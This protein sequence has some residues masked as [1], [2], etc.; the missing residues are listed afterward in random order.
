MVFP[1]VKLFENP[2]VYS[3]QEDTWFLKDILESQLRHELL[4]RSSS[5]SVCEV[6]VGSG[7]ISIA[8]AKKFPMIHFI[9]VDISQT[10][11]NLCYKNILACLLQPVKF[12]VVCMNLLRGFNPS[13]FHPNIIF[14]NPPYVRTS[15][16]EMKKGFLEKA[17]AGGPSG[18]AIIQEFLEDLSQ[19]SFEKV[20]FLSSIFNAND[21]LEK[22]Y[23]NIFEFHVVAERKIEN[24]RLLCYEV[25]LK[26]NLR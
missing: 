11:A 24:E 17:W 5:L 12:D 21:L 10:A 25:A 3:P 15:E 2:E 18:I 19:F 1:D 22:N 23:H 4:S 26:E 13:N 7:F 6:G 8:L 20:F 9:G 14:F 16:E